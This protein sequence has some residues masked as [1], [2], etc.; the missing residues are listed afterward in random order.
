[1]LQFTRAVEALKG[2]LH[3]NDSLA[4]LLVVFVHDNVMKFPGAGQGPP[5]LQDNNSFRANSKVRLQ[6]CH[7]LSKVTHSAPK[8]FLKHLHN[9]LERIAT[10]KKNGDLGD[11][12]LAVFMEGRHHCKMLQHPFQIVG[13]GM[14]KP[15]L[16]SCN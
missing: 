8:P 5:P 10:I 7:M 16:K 3:K 14:V 1:M 9:M 15:M 11:G 4:E 6:L 12:E 13:E 2:V